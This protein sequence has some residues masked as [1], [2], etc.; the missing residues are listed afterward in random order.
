MDRHNKHNH[1]VVDVL[2]PVCT[3]DIQQLGA[4]VR[5]IKE[6]SIE[7]RLIC[8]LNGLSEV[9]YTHYSSTLKDLGADVIVRSSLS[10]VANALNAGIP[11][12]KN[13][14]VARQDADDISDLNRLEILLHYLKANNLDVVGSFISILNDKGETIKLRR[15]PTTHIGCVKQ[16]SAKTCFSHPSILMRS[17]VFH[18][19]LYPTVGSEDYALF[20][21]IFKRFRF[22]NVS[23]PLYKWRSY[24]GQ[25]SRK[26]IPYLYLKRSLS[27]LMM[28]YFSF[29]EKLFMSLQIFITVLI[30][31]CKRRLI[32]WDFDENIPS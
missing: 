19:Y 6:Q 25:A 22:G 9:E 29:P 7:T 20:L 32:V 3:C 12:L 5:S 14:F 4:A 23:L 30:T 18:E 24:K 1:E 27:I 26:R 15:Y 2:L 16:L 13:E 28:D 11:Y 21:S 8:I 17:E 31:I 10:G